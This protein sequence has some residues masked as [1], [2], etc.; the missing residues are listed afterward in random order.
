MSSL[1]TVRKI[2][3]MV[4]SRRRSWRSTSSPSM[5]GIRQS[6][7]STSAAPPASK[8]FRV[9]PPL[10]KLVTA[11]PSSI[12]LRPSDSR[13]KSSSSTRRIRVG[14]TAASSAGGVDGKLFDAILTSLFGSVITLH[15]DEERAQS[16]ALKFPVEPDIEAAG[17]VG[18][19]PDDGGRHVAARLGRAEIVLDRARFHADEVARRFGDGRG[20]CNRRQMRH[21]GRYRRIGQR[22]RGFRG[23]RLGVGD[24]GLAP[25]HRRRLAGRRGGT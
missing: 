23:G 20:G 5:P 21:L 4:S 14:T 8:N 7:R 13:K 17:V 25:R 11:K 19:V 22:R 10:A 9:W 6:S 15:L 18:I 24:G 1:S 12:R 3:G 2:T 16:A